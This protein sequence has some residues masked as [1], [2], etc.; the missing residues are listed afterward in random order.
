MNLT[1]FARNKG[2]LDLLF[3]AP[4]NSPANPLLVAKGTGPFTFT[5]GTTAT[6]VDKVTGL[7]KTAAINALRVESLGALFEGPDTNYCLRSEELDA[8]EWVDT[9]IDV[10]PN[11][12]VAPDGATTADLL[13]ATAGNGTLIQDLGVI[14]YNHQMFSIWLRRKTGTGNIQLTSDGGSTWTTVAVTSNWTRFQFYAISSDPD[15]GIRFVT[16][17]DEVWAWGTQH[18]VGVPESPTS[19]IPTTDATVTRNLDKLSMPN[20]GNLLTGVGSI[21]YQV[22]VNTRKAGEQNWIMS[23]NASTTFGSLGYVYGGNLLVHD[24]TPGGV[25]LFAFAPSA[26]AHKVAIRWSDADSAFRA[27]LDGAAVVAG[28]FDNTVSVGTNSDVGSGFGGYSLRGHLKDLKIYS[29][30][31]SDAEL[32]TLTA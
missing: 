15:V 4:F 17:G 31:K 21:A 5:R 3:H 13:T 11:D 2:D 27:S 23:T 16:S 12:A 9:N 32:Q 30:A 8:A 24:E 26:A 10:T 22:Q 7:I 18:E 28:S 19:Y 25:I 1:V 29:T 14:G 20:A 6:Y